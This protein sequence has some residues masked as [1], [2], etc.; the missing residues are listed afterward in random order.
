[1]PRECVCMCFGFNRL[2]NTEL[3]SVVLK[4]RTTRVIGNLKKKKICARTP[5]KIT[6]A[7]PRREKRKQGREQ[8]R[9]KCRLV[10]PNP[11]PVNAVNDRVFE[12]AVGTPGQPSRGI[13][14]SQRNAANDGGGKSEFGPR[15]LL[16]VRTAICLE[17]LSDEAR[18]SLPQHR[19]GLFLAEPVCRFLEAKEKRGHKSDI[20]H[21][22]ADSL[23]FQS[24]PQD[25]S[26]S[27]HHLSDVNILSVTFCFL[28]FGPAPC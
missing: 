24:Y 21:F 11:V 19:G 9:V 7:S 22:F 12:G 1:M 16:S 6:L 23:A 2:C 4:I 26:S 14:I 10:K 25:S 5:R 13:A 17:S 8:R 18:C 28:W 15:L 3:T 20:I 27:P